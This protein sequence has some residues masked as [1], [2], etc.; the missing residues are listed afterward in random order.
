MADGHGALK[1]ILKCCSR[2]QDHN[3]SYVMARPSRRGQ[4]HHITDIWSQS[5][6]TGCRVNY[7]GWLHTIF[8]W[9]YEDR[10]RNN[11][12]GQVRFDVIPHNM[13]SMTRFVKFLPNIPTV[14]AVGRSISNV[15]YFFFFFFV[16]RK[17][18]VQ[19]SM[20]MLLWT[21]ACHLDSWTTN[22]Y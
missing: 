2:H 14:W 6:Q 17:L 18:L 9:K 12:V 13:Q 3:E 16:L 11:V 20:K 10:W 22:S 5:I 1:G 15:R 19:C 21:P 8:Q 7:F 4:P